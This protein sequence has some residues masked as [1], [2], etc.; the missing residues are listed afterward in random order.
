MLAS[1]FPGRVLCEAALL[2]PAAAGKGARQIGKRVGA[3]RPLQ[4]FLMPGSGECYGLRGDAGVVGDGQGCFQSARSRRI[5]GHKD[6]AGRA[7]SQG[8]ET[9]VRLDKGAGVCAGQADAID[10]EW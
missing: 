4:T 2:V 9:V 7:G 3:E 5:E 8:A 1:R 10:G 6:S